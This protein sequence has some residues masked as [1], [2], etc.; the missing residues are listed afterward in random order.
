SALCSLDGYIEDP[1][2]S[3]EWAAP[4]EEVHAFV[5]DLMRPMGMHLYGRRMYDTLA[6]WETMDTPDQ[7][8]IIRDFPRV[9]QPADKV[10]DSRTLDAAP[11]ARTRVERTFDAGAVRALK[12]SCDRDLLVGGAELAGEALRAGLVDDLHLFLNPILVGGGKSALP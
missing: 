2:G 10:V 11:T 7:P 4:S 8:E 1:H 12:E 9:C 6:V 5:N 3:F